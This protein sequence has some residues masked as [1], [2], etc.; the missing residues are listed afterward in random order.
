M[1][2]ET[3][4]RQFIKGV[5]GATGLVVA[6]SAQNLAS[7]SEMRLSEEGVSRG[8]N[9][10]ATTNSPVIGA[11]HPNNSESLNVVRLSAA[12]TLG[13]LDP[14]ASQLGPAQVPFDRDATAWNQVVERL[15]SNYKITAQR[16]GDQTT[17]V[18]ELGSPL[19]PKYLAIDYRFVYR[20]EPTDAEFRYNHADILLDQAADLLDRGMRD[21]FDWQDLAVKSFNVSA[22]LSE[23]YALDAIHKKEIEKGFYTVEAKQSNSALR[24]ENAVI[25]GTRT[26]AN[27]LNWLI[28]NKYTDSELKRQTD[29]AQMAAF[30]SHLAAYELPAQ[31]GLV[32]HIWEGIERTIPEHLK[33]AAF[34]QVWHSLVSQ[35][36]GLLTQQQGHDT[37][38]DASSRRLAGLEAKA[39]WDRSDVDFRRSRTKVARDIADLKMRAFTEPG[40]ALNY[41]E[42]M[43]PL[44][45]R[46][47]RDFRDAVSR[48]KAAQQ[49]LSLLYGYDRQLPTSIQNLLNQN[50]S[51]TYK[52]FDDCLAWVRDA[53]SWVVRFMQLDQQYVLPVSIRGLINNNTAWEAGRAAGS[54]Q[55]QLPESMFPNQRHIRLR[56]LSA[57]VKV[58]SDE[59]EDLWQVVVSVPATSYCKHL[60]GQNLSLDQSKIPPC[61]LARVK[62][63][64]DV[65]EPDVVGLTSLHNASPLG[66]GTQPLWKIS[67]NTRSLQGTEINKVKDLY[68]DLHLAVRT[69]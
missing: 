60:S 64:D 2:K 69:V 40:G 68:L 44:Q 16:S 31:G 49:G 28:Q 41:E 38:V 29:S 22:E 62:R 35:Q 20:P 9:V 51:N 6:S 24:A 57:S 19:E 23:Y 39:E 56:G 63:R 3:K 67:M 48:V 52:Y 42:R 27:Y 46:F 59:E 14:A 4:R 34:T 7:P 65:R 58:D 12:D 18:N 21:R 43:R 13:A 66:I 47:S 30:L 15:Q 55:I 10:A 37:T 50:S 25:S 53:I 36:V 11:A 8:K 33:E 17:R 61:R 5:V 26:A 54:W 45:E 1:K 32:K